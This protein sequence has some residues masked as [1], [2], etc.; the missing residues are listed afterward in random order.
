MSGPELFALPIGEKWLLYSPLLDLVSLVNARALAELSTWLEGGPEPC[1]SLRPLAE[2]LSEEPAPAPARRSGGLW[3][4]F[5]GIIPTRACDFGCVYCGFGAKASSSARMSLETAVRAVDWMTDLVK[6]R[7]GSSLELHFFGGEPFAAPEVVETALHRARANAAREGLAARFEVSTNGG[8]DED[9]LAFVI[10]YFDSVVLS[11]D[12][13]PE[14]QDRYRPFR[15]GQPSSDIVWR[16]AK[17]L[18]ASEV[19]LCLRVCVTNE[20][21]EGL[22]RSIEALCRDI[23]PS[24]IDLEPLKSTPGSRSFGI[25]PPEPYRFAR[26]LAACEAAAERYGTR[27]VFSAAE[28]GER[29]SGLC[30]VANDTIIVDPDGKIRACYLDPEDWIERG[31]DLG[32]GSMDGEG[33]FS[34]SEAAVDR[35]RSYATS[36]GRCRGC[37][38]RWHCA[39][40]CRVEN[41]G[42]L[43]AEGASSEP[44]E[45]CLR[46]RTVAAVRLLRRLGME[47]EASS[48]MSDED[49]MR[50][51]ARRPSDLVGAGVIA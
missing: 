2:A 13:S 25:L 34:V 16:N 26:A 36:C 12:G 40:G 44:P 45:W 11:I 30:P 27:L 35:I 22:D 7:R 5:L 43:A 23:G 33:R 39:G 29:R 6:A 15:G 17:A 46:A 19:E 48:F 42:L 3:P 4:D 47:A 37:F 9:R 18:A 8:F 14:F 20:N 49:A 24:I 10:D 28:L 1:A 32:Y 41:A 31:L 51:L 21:L 50:G 38:L